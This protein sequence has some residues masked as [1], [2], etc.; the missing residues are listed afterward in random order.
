MKLTEYF[1]TLLTDTV[2]LSKFKIEMLNER[3][4]KIYKALKAD[5]V[6]GPYVR[7]KIPQGSWA[8]R[9]I[10]KPQPGKEFD[11]DFLLWLDEHSEWSADPDRYIGE[12]YAALGRNSVYADMPRTP[13]CRCVRLTYANLCHVDIV[14]Y[15]I[16]A[17]G[18]QV[19]VNGDAN[20]W[21]DTNPT[22]FT[23][24]MRD[25]D[26]IT[27]GDLRRVIRLLKF[28]RDHKGTFLGTPSIILTTL[29]G[30]MV[31]ENKKIWDSGYYADVPTTLRNV[32]QDLDAWLQQNPT[33]PSIEDP[34]KC[35]TTFDHRWD[36][37]TYDNFR[38]K[39]HTYAAAIDDAYEETDKARSIELW[40]DIFGDG[41][42]APP[43]KQS[44][45]PFTP[46]APVPPTRT[47]RAG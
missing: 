16:L 25:K 18:R 8:H 5:P 3:V 17:D 46:V 35:G 47:G 38:D 34:S 2:N 40:Q 6:L 31:D 10:I 43:P 36:Y 11:A 26:E 23:Q 44:S 30:N 20:D 22:G 42:K 45:G 15:L 9:T 27:G 14:P 24:W 13:K 41:F 12:V 33:Q 39:M 28:L 4:E 32:T 19:I 29:L 37:T 1:N 21:E 7:G